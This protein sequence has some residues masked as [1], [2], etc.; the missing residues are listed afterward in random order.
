MNRYA[1]ALIVTFLLVTSALAQ[2]PQPERRFRLDWADGVYWSGATCDLGSSIGKREANPLWRDN[3]GIF[4]PGKNFAF[5][6]GFFGAF[7]GLEAHYR[8]PK[9]RRIIRWVKVGAGIAY[10]I[11]SVHNF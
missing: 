9:E 2:S 11:I 10:G 5:K 1:N 7:K 3:D 6:A 8:S 4:S